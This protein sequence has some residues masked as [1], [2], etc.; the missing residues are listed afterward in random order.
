MS[1]TRDSIQTLLK[2][3]RE[4][5]GYLEELRDE[6]SQLKIKADNF[7]EEAKPKKAATVEKNIAQSDE[8]PM[9]TAPPL[10][11]LKL[12]ELTSELEEEAE[13]SDQSSEK[14]NEKPISPPIQKRTLNVENLGA[15]YVI[16]PD[17]ETEPE[18][19]HL[20]EVHQ[21]V[22]EKQNVQAEGEPKYFEHGNNR[23]KDLR[24]YA[25]LVARFLLHHPTPVPDT[26]ADFLNKAIVRTDSETP[27]NAYADL[28]VAYQDV[29]SILYPATGVNGDTI[30]Q[31]I[32]GSKL[33]GGIAFLTAV[34][35]LVILP[36]FTFADLFLPDWPDASFG[37]EERKYVLFALLFL[38]AGCG[39]LTLQSCRI[40][41]AIHKMAFTRT[42]F[43]D[44]WILGSAGGILGL[45]SYPFVSSFSIQDDVERNLLM[46]ATSY[47][48]GFVFVAVYAFFNKTILSSQ[49]KY[50]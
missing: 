43:K 45:A 29:I 11:D 30:E 26:K 14:V 40:A 36:L 3:R 35:M 5:R 21:S 41:R 27:A 33:L 49:E 19:E 44:S 4:L 18:P 7:S 17:H 10:K 2:Q 20:P 24:R 23:E 25:V 12:S 6:I 15:G 32:R 34:L 39:S 8:V 47:V 38:W 31:S 50:L 16:L 37:G 13:K 48:I 42:H 28:K 22:D 46:A 1:A 9:P